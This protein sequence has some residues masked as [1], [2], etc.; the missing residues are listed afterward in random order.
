MTLVLVTPLRHLI[1]YPILLRPM[2]SLMCYLPSQSASS[3][4]SVVGATMSTLHDELPFF[5][6]DV[7]PLRGS[8]QDLTSI[9]LLLDH[10]E[11]GFFIS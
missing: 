7:E 9:Q 6:K 11:T 1:D 4:A 5:Y 10:D 3:L 8:L 2:I